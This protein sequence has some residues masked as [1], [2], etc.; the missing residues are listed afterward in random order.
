MSRFVIG[1]VDLV[2][3]KSRTAMLHGD[4][5]LSRLMVYA[6][7]IEKSRLSRYKGIR[8]GV[9]PISK[10]D[11]GLRKKHDGPSDPIVKDEG[12]SGSQ[13]G[14]PT[15]VTCGKKDFGKCLVGIGNR[16]SCGKDGHK[17]RDC[18]N[19]EAKGKE[20]NKYPP[21]VPEGDAPMRN[22]FYSLRARGSKSDDEDDDIVKFLIFVTLWKS[23][24]CS[25]A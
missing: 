1:V 19:G 23:K 21:K 15:S 10:I 2:K 17:V 20:S 22:P 4:M 25:R 9:D 7:S 16:S 12:G 14:K 13:G 24:R 3:E 5:N 6:Q 18:P 8:K 11:K